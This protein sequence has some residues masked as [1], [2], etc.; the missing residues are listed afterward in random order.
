MGLVSMIPKLYNYGA[1]AVNYTQRAVKASPDIIFGK[2]AE[3]FVSAAGK[4]TKGAGESWLT[5]LWRA[6]KTGG[7]AVETSIAATKAAKGGFL[8][9]AFNSLKSTPSVIKASVK[10]GAAVAK[11]A[12][13]SGIW[14]GVKGFFSGIGKKMPLIGN[15]MLVA[16]SLPNII[17]ATKEQGIGQGIA[18]IGKTGAGLAGGALGGAIAGSAFGPIG[19]LVG[20]IAGEWLTSK[21]VGKTYTEQKA[22]NEEKLAEVLELQQQVNPA[23]T[24]NIPQ[25][26]T[27]I[28][29][30]EQVPNVQNV[31]NPMNQM[32]QFNYNPYAF[33]NNYSDDIFMQNMKFDQ[34]A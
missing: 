11:A 7:K 19:S 29:P 24:G 33:N 9:Q 4:V 12:G 6:A 32:N 14:G 16:F 30:Q 8:K 27:K 5:A 34:I 10:E 17:T 21:I 28:P 31:T 20:W 13:K 3:T 1:K 26:G 25:D 18:E 2:G 15:L 22:E 23:F